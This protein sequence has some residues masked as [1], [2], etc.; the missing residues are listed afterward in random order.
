MAA[1]FVETLKRLGVIAVIRGKTAEEAVTL[2]SALLRGGVRGIEITFTTPNCCDAVRR[3][4]STAPPDAVVGVGTVLNAGQINDAVAAGATFAVS[5]HFH[6]ETLCA[7][8]KEGLPYLAGAITPT[9]IVQAWESGASAIKIF[10]GS[11]VG[12]EYIKAVRAPLPDIP[13]V[14]TGGV[15][16]ANMHEWFAAGVVAVGM[17]GNLAKGTPEQVETAARDTMAE[18]ARIRAVR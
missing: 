15:S 4:R 11:L 2:S 3:V 17:G 5:P 1:E 8:M 14:P 18:L 9:E 12:P 13:F 16:V 6:P 7:A 10:P